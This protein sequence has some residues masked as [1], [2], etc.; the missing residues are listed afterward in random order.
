MNISQCSH[1]SSQFKNVIILYCLVASHLLF[2][3]LWVFSLVSWDVITYCHVEK[4][5]ISEGWAA[6][7]CIINLEAF[8]SRTLKVKVKCILVHALRL[9]T[10][11]RAHRGSRGI[12]LPFLDRGTRTGWGDS[13]M[14]WQLFNPREGTGMHCTGGWVGH[15]PNL[16]RCRKSRPYRKSI[17]GPSSP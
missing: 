14:P 16:D 11:C 2:S 5:Y 4:Y 6:F 9:C 8:D 10:G 15:R 1:N 13:V 7:I 12:A 17:P 3:Q